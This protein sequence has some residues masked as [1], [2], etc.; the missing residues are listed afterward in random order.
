M[1]A[2]VLATVSFCLSTGA[3]L[4]CLFLL[5]R[6]AAWLLGMGKL[7]TGVLDLLFCCLCGGAV[8]LCALAVDSGRLRLYQAAL[9]GVGAW[10]VIAFFGPWARRLA[11]WLPRRFCKLWKVLGR[12][13]GFLTGHFHAKKEAGKHPEKKRGKNK[14]KQR[15]K[16]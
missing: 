5:F 9:Q 3:A 13:A 16:T 8:F 6:V 4:G 12:P 14:K 10:A 2:Q 1:S 15:K 11:L 7:G